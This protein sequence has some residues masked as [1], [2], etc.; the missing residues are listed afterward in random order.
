MEKMKAMT[1]IQKTE[2][3]LREQFANCTFF[4]EN[5]ADGEYRLQHS[6]RAAHA[7]R[8]IARKE[9]LDEEGLII[10]GLLHDIGYSLPFETE[11]GWMEHG[12]MSARLARPFLEQLDLGPE[13]VQEIC[14]GIAIHVDGKADFPGEATAFALS[15]GDADDVDRFDTYRIYD[16]MEYADFRNLKIEDKRKWLTKKLDWISQRI[17]EKS[18]TET[19]R[20]MIAERLL[21]QRQYYEK[22]LEQ[23][24]HSEAIDL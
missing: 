2:A 4:K 16:A 5:P 10:G 23:L 1:N 15:I 8:E 18:G 17:G 6:Y 13:R 11:D 12:R 19:A 20:Q 24:R 9:G 7:A 3:F 22:V 21:Y 14:Y